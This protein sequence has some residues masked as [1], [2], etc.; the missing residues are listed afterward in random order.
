MSQQLTAEELQQFQKLRNGIFETISILG[1]LNYRKTLLEVE[2]EALKVTI[3]D[4]ATK[5]KALLNEFGKKY[6]DGSI[7]TETGAITPIQ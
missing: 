4:N 3:K 1:E 5:E 6:G 7:N 2:L